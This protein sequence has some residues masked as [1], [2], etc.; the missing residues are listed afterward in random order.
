M[1]FAQKRII[2]FLFGVLALGASPALCV[3]LSAGVE[4]PG[5]AAY[6]TPGFT[7]PDGET[8]LPADGT[9]DQTG[10]EARI[11]DHTTVAMHEDAAAPS[12][13][14]S[15][16][17]PSADMGHAT[18]GWIV[19]AAAVGAGGGALF[20]FM[21]HGKG[22]DAGS[23]ADASLNNPMGTSGSGNGITGTGNGGKPGD[24]PSDVPEPGTIL[25]MGAGIASF[26]GR[27]RNLPR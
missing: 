20:A 9:A 15:V 3:P 24:H 10:S 25:L 2:F 14:G 16:G 26:L 1:A 11:V 6:T 12:D 5:A 27:R 17:S 13:L 18:P 7:D 8:T 21:S 19:P 23:G 22:G 4:N